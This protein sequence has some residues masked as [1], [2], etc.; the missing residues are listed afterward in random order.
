MITRI[1]CMCVFRLALTVTVPFAAEVIYEPCCSRLHV[2]LGRILF[3]FL[4]RWNQQTASELLCEYHHWGP[5][6]TLSAWSVSDSSGL[7]GKK[8]LV[9]SLL[10][11]TVVRN[12]WVCFWPQHT[13][14]NTGSDVNKQIS[15]RETLKWVVL[16]AS[17]PD[18]YLL[19]YR[20]KPLCL[21]VAGIWCSR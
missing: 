8:K 3:F 2:L 20:W 19:A 1:V 7:V 9:E 5:T 21:K 15:W 12:I 10:V 14:L 16:W 11:S 13:H 17:G 4:V 6:L 18:C